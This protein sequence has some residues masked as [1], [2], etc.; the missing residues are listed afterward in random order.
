MEYVTAIILGF[1]QGITEF[2]PVSSTG[3]LILAR[4][5]LDIEDSHALAFDAMLHL[6]TAGAVIVYF[7]RDIWALV[8]TFLRYVGRMPVN[9]RD[10]SLLFAIIF[11]TIPAAVV[12]FLLEDAMDAALRAPLIVAGLLVAG[13]ALLGI[14]EYFYRKRPSAK[15][16]TVRT[17]VGIGLFQT[18]ALLPGVS[19]SG[20]SIAGGMLL[21][22]S[23]AEATRFAFLLAVPV[24]LGAGLKK[25]VEML[26][27]GADAAWDSIFLGVAVA[28]VVGIFAIHFMLRFLR[29]HT[30]WPFIFY[31]IALAA[32]VIL[33]VFAQK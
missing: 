15:Q 18:L 21:G 28:F 27:L 1:V 17:G 32:A 2:L 8:H 22:L 23:R 12:G 6:A 9:A 29:A 16:I 31:R 13:S 30:F 19:R 25:C 20:A 14:A 33:V 7:W 24:I 26:S 3:H 5:F 4:S 11:G 10:V